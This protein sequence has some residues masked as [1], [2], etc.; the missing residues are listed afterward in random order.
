MRRRDH[1]HCHWHRHLWTPLLATVLNIET[2]I[3][4]RYAMSSI[5]AHQLFSDFDL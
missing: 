4:Y 5:Y 2:Y 1:W 3:W